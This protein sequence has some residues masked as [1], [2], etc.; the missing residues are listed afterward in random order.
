MKS[1]VLLTAMLSGLCAEA[2][3]SPVTVEPIFLDERQP[4][5]VIAAI[6]FDGAIDE[7]QFTIDGSGSLWAPEPPAAMTIVIGLS[8]IG[9]FALWRRARRKKRLRRRR[10]VRMRA[11]MAER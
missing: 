1:A 2:M 10:A 8:A 4:E 6:D 11:I 9:L 7:T 5:L 3:A